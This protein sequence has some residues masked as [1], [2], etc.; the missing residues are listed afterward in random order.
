MEQPRAQTQ[1]RRAGT[2][3]RGQDPPNPRPTGAPP[4]NLARFSWDPGRYRKELLPLSN[5]NQEK[6]VLVCPGEE[7]DQRSGP[8]A[9]R[10]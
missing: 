1:A 6:G 2:D 7:R 5:L 10:V 8:Y 9:T 4:P 3:T